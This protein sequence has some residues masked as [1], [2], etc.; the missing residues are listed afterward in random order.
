MDITTAINAASCD[1]YISR[2]EEIKMRTE[3][4]LRVVFFSSSGIRF[5][6]SGLQVPG[7]QVFRSLK[8]YRQKLQA[9][10]T[11]EEEAK[12]KKKKAA[13]SAALPVILLS[14]NPLFYNPLPRVHPHINIFPI[15]LACNRNNPL[16]IV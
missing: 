1:H 9:K 13:F 11:G 12:S 3:N 14:L 15:L 6:S 2:D 5:R 7:L 4:G 10:V 8:S 16:N